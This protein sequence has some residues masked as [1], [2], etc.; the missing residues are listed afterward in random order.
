MAQC[1]VVA[2]TAF[3]LLSQIR[4]QT[5]S[6]IVSSTEAILA[7]WN[8]PSSLRL[9]RDVC[10]AWLEG[11]RDFGPQAQALA[12]ILENFAMY[13]KTK[14]VPDEVL[15]A[16]LSWG[17]EYYHHM[18]RAGIENIRNDLKDELL[19]EYFEYLNLRFSQIT[20]KRGLKS[21][22]KTEEELIRFLQSEIESGRVLL[23]SPSDTKII[24][25]MPAPK[26]G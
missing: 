12:E 1:A 9:R 4:M 15:W 21:F 10:Q 24:S 18:F 6:H 14:A 5:N 23:G 2:A 11:R 13:S 20:R 19:Y 16:I 26:R 8:S 7:S 3:M 25:P 17:F 22:A